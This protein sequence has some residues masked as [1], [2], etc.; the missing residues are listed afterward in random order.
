MTEKTE[1]GIEDLGPY[2]VHSRREIVSLLRSVS[3]HNQ[4]V[5]MI[6]SNGNESIMT[7][8]LLVDEESGGVILDVAPGAMQNQR[9]LDSSNISFETALERIRILFFTETI[10]RVE[11]DGLPAFLIPI[12]DSVIRLQR[13]EFYR[14]STLVANPVRC[15]FFLRDPQ[16]KL[17]PKTVTLPLK[18]VSNGGI[19]VMDD[20][21]QLDNTIGTL[22]KDCRI[23]FPGNTVTATLLIRNTEESK[24]Q[25]G[26][27]VRRLGC[28][29]VNL[30]NV[31]LMSVQRYIIKLEREQNA[32]STGLG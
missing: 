7:S 31:M 4:L 3:S 28:A 18:N 9:I 25:N 10:E 29:F 1:P 13:R 5:R 6:F 20:L 22:Y 27:T 14:V 23:D 21:Q 26:K 11:C 17:P 32:K 24:L 2:R 12:P 16:G 8:I 19:A 30:P 15:T